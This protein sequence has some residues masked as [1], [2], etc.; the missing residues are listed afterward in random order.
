MVS[1]ALFFLPLVF[2]YRFNAFSVCRDISQGLVLCV[3]SRWKVTDTP[4]PAA[5][6]QL[7]FFSVSLLLVCSVGPACKHSFKHA[8]SRD[9]SS[10]VALRLRLQHHR[11]SLGELLPP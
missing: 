8:N 9:V 7:L 5:I 2:N 4:R 11:R 10:F 1:K 3:V 6:I